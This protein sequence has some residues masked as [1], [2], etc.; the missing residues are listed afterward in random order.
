MDKKDHSL[1]FIESIIEEDLKNGLKREDL[2][3][4]FPPEPNGYLHIGHIKAICLNFNLGQKYGAAVNLRFDDTNPQNE[5]SKYVTAIKNDVNWLGYSWDKECFASDYFEQLFEWAKY[6]IDEGLAYVD[7]QSS[8]EIA[9]QKGTPTSP[10]KNS[11]YRERSIVESKNIFHEMAN[12]KHPEGT[13]V[14]RA[15]I[16]MESSNMLL[17]DPVIYRVLN[18]PHHRTGN[19]WCV[20]PMYDWTHGQS[21]YLEPV[22]YTHLRAHETS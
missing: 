19:K 7:S 12:G 16:D 11:P 10:G 9:Y 6:L 4:R 8:E 17:R 5:E 15:K 14:L 20:Y 13:H 1:N 3:F 2:R 21:D 18:K 22:S